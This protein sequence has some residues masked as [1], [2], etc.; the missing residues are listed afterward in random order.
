MLEI[1]IFVLKDHFGNSGIKETWGN[2]GSRVCKRLYSS[3]TLSLLPLPLPTP[4]HLPAI[5]DEAHADQWLV[6][7][8]DQPTHPTCGTLLQKRCVQ[9]MGQN[10]IPVFGSSSDY[11]KNIAG[12]F[13]SGLRVV[14]SLHPQFRM[15]I[16]AGWYY[17]W[18]YLCFWNFHRFCRYAVWELPSFTEYSVLS[19]LSLQGTE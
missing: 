9:V 1:E 19:I 18:V 8:L 13:G 17:R 5:D 11:C 3:N 15:A 12:G 16:S 7:K 4:D 10:G 6:D 2:E 14:N